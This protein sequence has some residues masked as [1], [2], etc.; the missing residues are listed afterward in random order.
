M[1]LPACADLTGEA[2]IGKWR[3]KSR[4]DGDFLVGDFIGDSIGDE[5]RVEGG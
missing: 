2:V 1:F 5:G 4:F 3:T